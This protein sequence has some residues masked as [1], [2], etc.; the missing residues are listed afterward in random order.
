MVKIKITRFLVSL[1]R[2]L[3][4]DFVVG[5]P[6]IGLTYKERVSIFEELKGLSQ[7]IDNPHAYKQSSM[8]WYIS[9]HGQPEVD[10]WVASDDDLIRFQN[11]NTFLSIGECRDMISKINNLK[12]GRYIIKD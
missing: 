7:I 5:T 9:D 4:K 2:K 8:Y 1:I 6:K 12:I 11:K 10:I 3:D